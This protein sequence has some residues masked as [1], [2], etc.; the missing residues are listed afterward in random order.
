MD[1]QIDSYWKAVQPRVG[2]AYSPDNKTVIR[3]GAGLFFDRN[4]MTFFFITGNQKTIPGF[5]PGIT[6]PQVRKGA[7][8]GGWQL[9][10]A[11]A[12]ETVDG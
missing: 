5:L 8:T 4:N 3:A 10:L 2:L 11:S 1:Q 9:N 6:L 12:P 7:E